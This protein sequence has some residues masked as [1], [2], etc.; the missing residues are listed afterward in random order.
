MTL[1]IEYFEGTLRLDAVDFEG[2]REEAAR[3]AAAGLKA[4]D[5]A[6]QARILDA[7]GRVIATVHPDER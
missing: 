1:K 4:I 5:A 2:S 3:A 7:A 6:T